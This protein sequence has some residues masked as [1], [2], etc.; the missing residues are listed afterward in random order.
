MPRLNKYIAS[1]GICSRRKADELILAGRVRVNDRV[2]EELGFHVREKDKVYVDNKLVRPQNLEYYKFFKPAGYITTSDDEKNRKTIYDI[3]PAELK[4]LKP[5]G[6]LDKDSTGLI[7]LT[8]DGELINDMTHPSI[9]VPKVY[10]VHINGKFTPDDAK[11]MFEGIEIE[12]DTGEKKTAYAETL[13]VEIGT[14][15]SAIQVTLYQGINRQIRKMF[16]KLGFEVESLK[17]IQHATI[18]LEG[19]KRGQVKVLKPKQVKELKNY[20]A[21]IK[22]EYAQSSNNG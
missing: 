20:I 18:T 22:R 13:P 7:I 8:N 15:S 2:V 4:H 6:R 14:N 11:K 12:T 5:V 16:A 9:K 1:T 17:R 3:I 19:M 10:L 21:K